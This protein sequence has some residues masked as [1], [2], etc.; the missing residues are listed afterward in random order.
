MSARV[1]VL[2]TMDYAIE[3]AQRIADSCPGHLGAILY[4]ADLMKARAAVAELIAFAE[5][6]SFTVTDS[7]YKDAYLSIT[8]PDKSVVFRLT[9][10]STVSEDIADIERRRVAAL[11]NIGPSA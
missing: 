6:F 8:R 1:D 7:Y 3:S 2:I 5:G 4:V 11:A 10:S 9:N